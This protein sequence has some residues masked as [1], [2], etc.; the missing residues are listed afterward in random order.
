M[1]AGQKA[2]LKSVGTCYEVEW[3]REKFTVSILYK[4]KLKKTFG[5][6][7]FYLSANFYAS[8]KKVKDIKE[9]L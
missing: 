1:F 5:F 2:L 6:D 8:L 7:K 9:V 4:C 3:D